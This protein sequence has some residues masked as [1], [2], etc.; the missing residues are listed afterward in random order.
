MMQLQRD[1]LSRTRTA[2]TKNKTTA[3]SL[4]IKLF[5]I[6]AFLDQSEVENKI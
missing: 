2:A 4:L 3:L 5:F 6:N 1:S